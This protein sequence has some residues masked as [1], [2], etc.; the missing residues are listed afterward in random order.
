MSAARLPVAVKLIVAAVGMLSDQFFSRADVDGK[1]SRSD[2][3][4]TDPCAIRCR[5]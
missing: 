4:K 1:W 5:R 2:S 3:I